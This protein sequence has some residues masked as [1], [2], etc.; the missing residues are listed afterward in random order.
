MF[1]TEFDISHLEAS[2]ASDV[3]SAWTDTLTTSVVVTISRVLRPEGSKG[4]KKN[5]LSTKFQGLIL[6]Q[7]WCG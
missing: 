6:P 5:G 4:K 2:Y 1:L 3:F 7:A